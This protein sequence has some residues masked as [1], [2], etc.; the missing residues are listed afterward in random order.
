LISPSALPAFCTSRILWVIFL[1][2]LLDDDSWTI[3]PDWVRRMELSSERSFWA[4]CPSFSFI[5]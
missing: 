3:E 2:P 5:S 4:I 1:T